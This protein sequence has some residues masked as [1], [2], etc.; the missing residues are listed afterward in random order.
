M[1]G[2]SVLITLSLGF[3]PHYHPVVT[4]ASA[5]PQ[6]LTFGP[7]SFTISIAN[8]LYLPT[9]AGHAILFYALE[10]KNGTARRALHLYRLC[11]QAYG[12]T[13]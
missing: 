8:V 7:M 12:L 4:N 9:F 13:Q 5:S 11:D 10:L 3:T 2:L 6:Q 1:K